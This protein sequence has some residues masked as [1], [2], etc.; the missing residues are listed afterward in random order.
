MPS[1]QFQPIKNMRLFLV[2]KLSVYKCELINHNTDEKDKDKSHWC[3]HPPRSHAPDAEDQHL[4]DLRSG[5][6]GK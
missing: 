3:S 5:I 1:G 6:N 4:G 2:S